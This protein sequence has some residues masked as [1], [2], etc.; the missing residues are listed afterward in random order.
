MSEIVIAPSRIQ[1]RRTFGWRAPLD[2]NGLPPIYVGRGSKFGNPFVCRKFPELA[3]ELFSDLVWRDWQNLPS[4][5]AL[6][7]FKFGGCDKR[8]YYERNLMC[9]CSIDKPCHADVLLK[10]FDFFR[11]GGSIGFGLSGK[12]DPLNRAAFVAQWRAGKTSDEL[13]R[14]FDISYH[15]L[16]AYQ[17]RYRNVR[18]WEPKTK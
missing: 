11:N 4:G 6:A 2:E 3:V 1:R 14:I 17:L 9:F 16:L 10:Y 12:N 5:I 13:Q 18:I 7:R 8:P 15:E